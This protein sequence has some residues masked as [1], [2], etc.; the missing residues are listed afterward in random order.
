MRGGEGKYI[1]QCQ[2]DKTQYDCIWTQYDC[3][4][5]VIESMFLKN[6]TDVK[7]GKR[8]A[9][10]KVIAVHLIGIPV[11]TVFIKASVAVH[12]IGIPVGTVFI[13]A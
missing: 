6:C 13:K 9:C 12:L 10:V 2:V 8:L 5:A 1:Q 11:G 7:S 3:I 4:C